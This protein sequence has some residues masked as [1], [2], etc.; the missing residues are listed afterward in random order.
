MYGRSLL[1]KSKTLGEPS[2]GCQRG[3]F[4]GLLV[5]VGNKMLQEVAK[6]LE[7]IPGFLSQCGTM[8]DNV[9]I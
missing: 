6:R 8:W 2:F 5:V 9:K 7:K 4:I 1:M 3:N